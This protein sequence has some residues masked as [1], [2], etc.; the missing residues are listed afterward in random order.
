MSFLVCLVL[1][2]VAFA[3]FGAPFEGLRAGYSFGFAGKYL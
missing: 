1:A 2:M 3:A